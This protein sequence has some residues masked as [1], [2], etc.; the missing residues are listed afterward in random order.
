MDIGC[1]G[2]P[3]VPWAIALDL[4]SDQYGV[5]HSGNAPERQIQFG[6]D[7]RSLPFKDGVLDFSFSSH[8]LEDFF[9]WDPILREWCRVLK[10]GGRLIIL[11]PDKA[12]WKAALDR[13]QPPNCAHQHESHVGELSEY[14]RVMGGLRVIEDRLTNLFD[15]DYTIL[16]V[17]E[18]L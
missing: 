9:D 4:P 12:L 8:L 10:R 1:G 17:A 16:F 5:Y 6:G 15:G 7:A 2:E 3:V 14:A 13:G 18:K 11:V